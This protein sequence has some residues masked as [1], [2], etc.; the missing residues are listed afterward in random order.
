MSF[1][2][3]GRTEIQ[4][5][6]L[7]R[8]CDVLILFLALY[9]VLKNMEPL[10]FDSPAETDLVKGPLRPLIFLCPP[11]PREWKFVFYYGLTS[12]CD[13]MVGT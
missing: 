10:Y 11:K 2:N 3:W 13:P 6:L 1:I 9:R 5:Q 7:K 12:I 4:F 8:L